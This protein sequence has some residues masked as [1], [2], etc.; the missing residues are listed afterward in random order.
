MVFQGP[1]NYK[2]AAHPY[3]YINSLIIDLRTCEAVS[4]S[5]LYT[6]DIGFVEIV[7][8][9]FREQIRERLAEMTGASIDNI[10]ES[11]EDY[12]PWVS[13]ASLLKG[14]VGTDEQNG[15]PCFMTD[16]AIGI[17]FFLSHARGD[18]VEILIN[19]DDLV[20]FEV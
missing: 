14:L 12:L 9:S 11:L 5:D 18:H 8:S 3:D 7:K 17:C 13:D 10:P 1:C 6:I 4:L 19:Y 16:T 20:L 2:E 15:Y